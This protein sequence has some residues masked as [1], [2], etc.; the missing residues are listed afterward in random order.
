MPA[1]PSALPAPK[2]V[3]DARGLAAML[4]ELEGAPEI[5]VDTEADSFFSYRE[6]VCLIQVSA[7]G[8]DWIV[9]P[10]AG[11]DLAPL[12][13]LL[14]DE[15]RLKIFHDGEFDILILR[16]EYGFRFRGIFDTRIAAAALGNKTP[17]LG[18]VLNQHFGVELDKS[19]QRSD[20]S[21]RP[22]SPQQISYARYDTHYLERLMAQQLE[23]LRARER[24]HIVREEVRR[25]ER[26]EPAARAPDPDAAYKI[27][28]A[29]TLSPLGLRALHALHAWRET[30]AEKRDQPLFKVLNNDQLIALAHALPG[31][32]RELTQPGCLYGRQ[33]R[34]Y[35]AAVLAALARARAAGPLERDPFP[36]YSDAERRQN[37]ELGELVDRLK[38]WRKLE[39]ERLDL[40]SALVL[41]RHALEAI[42]AQ[43]LSTPEAVRGLESVLPWQ[44]ASFAEKIAEV[45]RG[46]E[47]DLAAGQIDFRSR[48]RR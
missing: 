16:R 20:W 39:S 48:K 3:D 12:G 38:Q 40:E 33:E 4:A 2:I 45:V 19:L 8:S 21:Q 11:F 31:H 46:F 43:R 25:L 32:S 23:L 14:A 22:L 36:S 44:A 6:R 28:G 9:D 17:G 26:L 34:T 47:R 13:A 41:N 7:R 27:K 29:R 24:E 15:S 42:A 37:E 1:N 18:A 35:G 5:A 10:L 30:E